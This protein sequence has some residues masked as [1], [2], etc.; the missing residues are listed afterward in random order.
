MPVKGKNSFFLPLRLGVRSFFF[1]CVLPQIFCRLPLPYLQETDARQN[2]L[3]G[4][5]MMEGLN[6]PCAISIASP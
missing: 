1:I 4:N 3:S 5:S 2:Q 6:E